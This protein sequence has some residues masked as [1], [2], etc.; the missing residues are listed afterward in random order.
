[1]SLRGEDGQREP[2]RRLNWPG[3]F[4]GNDG[5]EG[6]SGRKS[7]SG[8]GSRGAEDR[9][10]A[11]GRVCTRGG[12]PIS[13]SQRHTPSVFPRRRGRGLRLLH[14]CRCRR[15]AKLFAAHRRGKAVVQGRSRERRS[16]SKQRQSIQPSR[17]PMMVDGIAHSGVCLSLDNPHCSMPAAWCLVPTHCEPCT[18]PSCNSL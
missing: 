4:R 8:G 6:G 17:Q 1:M 7:G 10:V 5:F 18:F 9:C 15:P 11:L 12:F 14:N 13:I 16:A 2:G 3:P